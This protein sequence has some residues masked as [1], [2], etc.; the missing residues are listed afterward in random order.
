M[1]TACRMREREGA[2][3]GHELCRKLEQAE[4][5]AAEASLS[6]I[7]SEGYVYNDLKIIP[8][9][10][11]IQRNERKE[12]KK[13]VIFAISSDSGFLYFIWAAPGEKPEYR[14]PA[15]IHKAGNH[16]KFIQIKKIRSQVN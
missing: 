9:L 13:I 2:D 3:I 11:I 12:P 16:I 4:G 1:E 7:T 15:D 8:S 5:N 6:L 10:S 14:G